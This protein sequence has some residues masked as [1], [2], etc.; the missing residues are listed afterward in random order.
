MKHGAKEPPNRRIMKTFPAL[1]MLLLQKLKP[2]RGGNFARWE[3]R[4]A[5]NI[6]KHNLIVPSVTI[7]QLRG[8]NL[9]DEAHNNRF[10]NM[11]VVVGAGGRLNLIGYG[12]PGAHL[13]VANKGQATAG[14]I[15]VQDM[16]VFAGKPVLPTLLQCIQ[17]AAEAIN[18]IEQKGIK[19]HRTA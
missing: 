3:V 11:T 5:D 9:F 14:I 6:D 13:K 17:L 4:K 16:E 10:Q 8:I 19:R 1:V 18:L 15:F 12:I 7:T 2:Y